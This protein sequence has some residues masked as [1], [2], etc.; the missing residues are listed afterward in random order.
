MILKHLANELG[1]AWW[2][3]KRVQF[4]GEFSSL[5]DDLLKPN[6]EDLS[7]LHVVP[8]IASNGRE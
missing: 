2:D 8:A 7:G 4:P 5:V 6:R 3:Q 1:R